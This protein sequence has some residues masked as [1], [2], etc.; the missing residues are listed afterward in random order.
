MKKIVM[1]SNKKQIDSLVSKTD[2][3]LLGLENYS[4]NFG[5]YFNLDEI[6]LIT[7]K[8]PEKEIFISCNKNIHENELEGLK[9]VLNNL[10]D[11]NIKGIYYYD[12]CFVELKKEGLIKHDLIWH[13][14]HLT[15]NYKT[16]NFWT[17]L[18]VS[19]VCLS[20]EITLDEIKE[21]RNNTNSVI[22]IPIFGY[23]PMFV[24][25]RKLVTSYLETF[26]IKS[27]DNIFSLKK[28]GHTYPITNTTDGVTVYSSNILNGLKES[29]E[30]DKIKVDYILLN[31]FLIDDD[32]FLDVLDKYNI[33]DSENYEELEKDI[34]SKIENTDT[35]FLYKETIYRVKKNEK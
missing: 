10:N 29:I 8:Y 26:N 33:V 2:G 18:G 6:K 1:V 30:L 35:G 3:F 25:K 12:A 19:G 22:I 31:S 9:Q 7:S 11:I 21:I 15:T 23:I 14:E 27:K 4:V 5:C 24:S 32:V 34:N 16:V 20:S 13:Q 17:S 28:E